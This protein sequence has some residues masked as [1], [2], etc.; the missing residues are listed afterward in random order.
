MT[1]DFESFYDALQ[2]GFQRRYRDGL[3]FSAT[4]TWA[5]NQSTNVA[6]W[7]SNVIER[8]D[9]AND[10]RHRVVVT[11]TYE[12]PFGRSR[13]GLMGALLGNWQVNGVAIWQSGLP[14]DITNATARSN[15]GG[16]DRPNLVGDPGLE[17]R[18]VEQWFNTVAFEPQPANTIGEA[19]VERNLLH[20]P[21][22]SHVDLSLFKT[23]PLGDTMR[24]QLRV[25]AFNVFNNASFGNPNGALGS[26]AF[27][28]I[29]STIGTPR[30]MQF[31]AKFL[32]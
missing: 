19:M 32:F 2:L 11:A 12:L 21:S 3:A 15:T 6:P 25:E 20:G 28:Q 24:L 23:L 22:R 8:F 30:Q 17:N 9:A 7:D 5:R 26:A 4:Y 13:T 29:T 10:V 27:G 14:F 31:A 16:S 1:S 18:T